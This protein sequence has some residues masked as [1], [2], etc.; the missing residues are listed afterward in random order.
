MNVTADGSG[1]MNVTFSGTI[2]GGNAAAGPTGSAVPADADYIGFSVAGVLTG[3]SAVNPLPI[4]GSISATNPSVSATGAA[5]PADATMVGGTDGTDLRALLTDTTGQLKVLIENA[6]TVA[7]GTAA[8]NTAGWP[9]IAGGLAE[10]TAAWTNGTTVNT[11]LQV[12]VGGYS[13]V[14]VTLNQGTTLTGGVVTFEVS[15]TTAF[16]NAYSITAQPQIST[17]AGIAA[18]KYNLAASTNISFAVNVSGYA[19]FRVRLS[20]VISGTATVNVGITPS[21]ATGLV[22]A[23]VQS[24]VSNTPAGGVF[25]VVDNQ[26]GV[27]GYANNISDGLIVSESVY[28][29]A[30]SG[31]ANA[32]LQG[33]SKSRVATV[34]KTIQ[35]TASGN[36][37]GWT[38]GSGNKFRLT[39]YR[40][41]LTDNVTFT[42]GGV[43]TVSF[44][45]G[46]TGMPIAYDIYV[47]ATALTTLVG[48]AYDSGYVSLGAF[49]IL[50]ATANNVLNVNLSGALATGN[51]R[52]LLAGTEE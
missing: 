23:I 28:G 36:T 29:G 27:V 47:P 49:G 40:I 17:A 15:D 21:S 22:Y 30:F 31:T 34:F 38:P 4:T 46:T 8:A 19:A 3:V 26:T 10:S 50:S 18:S 12:N 44:Q 42:G 51:A 37:A 33:W 14:V 20:T 24:S 41:S 43:V 48:T 6:P 52:I 35:A 45:D 2:S 13:T 1:N 7:Q 25:L 5:V 11:A 32:A 9:V 16:T 39:A